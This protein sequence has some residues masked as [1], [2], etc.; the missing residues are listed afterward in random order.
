MQYTRLGRT[1][2]KVSRLCLGTMNFG[3]QTTEKDSFAIMDRALEH[4]INF[5]DTANVY[6]WKLG[7]GITEQIVGRWLAQ[8]GGR[9]DKV[10]LATK[11]F[12]RMGD[13]PNHSGLSALHIRRACEDS[14]LRLK[15]DHVDLYQMHHVD[16]DAPWEEIWQAMEQLVREGKVL[17]VGSSNFAGWHIARANEAAVRRNFLGLV[18]E[19]SFYNLMVR[20]VEL[21]VLPACEGYGMGFIPWSPLRQGLLAG[22]RKGSAKGRRAT[23]QVQKLATEHRAPLAAYAR[24][25]REIGEEPADVA[26]AWLLRNPVVTAP[27]VGPRTQEQLDGALRALEIKLN[28]DL[29]EKLDGLF[30]GPGGTAPEAYAW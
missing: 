14:L 6:G 30:P 25:C 22:V 20:T 23:P 4:G 19:Q 3:P 15:T 10:V 13:W 17:Y 26:L 16:R 9:R 8:G 5:F 1:A 24:L 12:G 28:K 18:S 11:V 27:I 2:L 29:M 21:E 7:E